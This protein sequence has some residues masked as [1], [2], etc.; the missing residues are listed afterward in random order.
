[1]RIIKLALL[2][3][4]FFLMLITITS[5]FFPSHIRISRNIRIKGTRELVM[6][7]ISNPEKW[8]NWYPG[9]DSLELFF[10]NGEVKGILLDSLHAL[11]IKSKNDS[12][13]TVANSGINSK[14]ITMTWIIIPEKEP[15]NVTVQWY[16]DFHLQ[17]YPWG[18]F[19]SLLFE[20]SYGSQ[21]NMGLNKL[22][23]II[24]TDQY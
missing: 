22:K 4:I 19:K 16:I 20:K 7:Q 17:W 12:I 2:S 10:D 11:A 21:M 9:A 3:V 8:K 13:V 24:E 18:K 23:R 1:M 5:F 14:Q 15:G 6:T